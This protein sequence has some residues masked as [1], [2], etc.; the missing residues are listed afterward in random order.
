MFGRFFAGLRRSSEWQFRGE[1]GL[2]WGNDR[3]FRGAVH[4]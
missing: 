1:G 3:L 2:D 4:L